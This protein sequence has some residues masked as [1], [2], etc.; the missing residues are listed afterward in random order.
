M[1]AQQYLAGELML[2]FNPQGTLAE[3]IRAGGAG[4]YGF[5]TKTGAGTVVAEGKIVFTRT[6]R[7]PHGDAPAETDRRVL[8]EIGRTLMVAMQQRMGDQSVSEILVFG[9][10][11]DHQGLIEAIRA[12]FELAAAEFDPFE[13][14]EIRREGIPE[15]A[16]SFAPLLGMLLDEA[17]GA[18]H[19]IDFLHP[20]RAPK[21]PNRRRLLAVIAGLLV[22]GGLFAWYHQS[23]ELKKLDGAIAALAKTRD[24]RKAQATRAYAQAQ[25]VNSLRA[26][27]NTEMNWLDELRDLSVRFPSGAD[28]VVLQ[29]AFSP[30]RA[31]GATITFSGLA[32]DPK[33]VVRMESNI[34][35]RY[36]DIRSKRVQERGPQVEVGRPLAGQD[37]HGGDVADQADDAWARLGKHKCVLEQFIPFQ[38]EISVLVARGRDGSMETFGPMENTHAHHILDVSIYPSASDPEVARQ[39]IVAA[40]RVATELDLVGIACVEFFETEAGEVV[41]NEIAPRPHNSGHHTIESCLTSQFSQQVRVVAGLPPGDSRP[42]QY[43]G[44]SLVADHARRY[45]PAADAHLRLCQLRQRPAD[46]LS[47]RLHADRVHADDRGDERQPDRP[48]DGAGHSAGDAHR[49]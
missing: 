48:A 38:R 15:H 34:R 24:E 30:G 4:I 5:Y 41:A 25:V 37:Q 6:A 47:L 32:R 39:A 43:R 36:H 16:G 23:Q 49:T 1:F 40:R 19:A 3:R 7:I 33:I 10:P 46:G 21:P 42:G 11:G 26:W 18:K 27:H 45:G 2:E 8:A 17:D 13:A 29:M 12:Q 14:V 20:R 9:S 35:D 28:M 44:R 31:G 22:I